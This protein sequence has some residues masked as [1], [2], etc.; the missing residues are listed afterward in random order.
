MTMFYAVHNLI[1]PLFGRPEPMPL[2]PGDLDS[3]LGVRFVI[4][5][6]LSTAGKAIGSGMLAVAG[7]V[8]LL[9]FLKRKPLTHAVSSA[10]F[11]WA[12]INDMFNPGT[13]LLDVAI[14]L[15][16]IVI[17]TGVILYGGLLATVAALVTHFILLRGSITTDLS[18]WRATP[19]LTYLLVIGGVGLAAAYLART[20]VPG[21]KARPT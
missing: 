19:G 14:G 16:I 3:M 8:T 15:G 21:L 18:S 12:V 9:I 7:V 11:V 1:P 20:S 2:H 13:P 10:I 17:W 6:M 4:A 5:R